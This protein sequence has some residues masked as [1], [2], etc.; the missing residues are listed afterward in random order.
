MASERF[1]PGDESNRER[2]DEFRSG[3]RNWGRWWENSETWDAERWKTMASAWASMWHDAAD[4][5]RAN[6]RAAGA[7]STC[8]YC[9]EEIK[10]AAILCKHCGIWLTTPPETIPHAYGPPRR[11][12]RS[13]VDSMA[14][15]VLGGLGRFFGVD[16][17]WIRMVYAL[18]TVFTAFIPGIVVYGILA[19]VI[20]SDIPQK[21]P[22]VE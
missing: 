11:L 12:T 18:A 3:R 17:T 14:A 19:L 7:T 4:R 21:G 1:V 5:T 2:G 20:P 10:A 6:L 8:P 16:P 13:S 15:G 22:S 9:A